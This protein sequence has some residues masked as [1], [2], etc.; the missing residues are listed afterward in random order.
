M[1]ISLIAAMGRNREIGKD[2][3]LMWRLPNDMKFFRETTEGHHV[4]MGRKNYESIPEAFRPF[5]NRVNLVLSRNLNFEAPGCVLFN[6]LGRAVRYAQD[7]AESELF[8]IGGEQ[9]YQLALDEGFV[10]TI[11]LTE[12]EGDFPG[13]EAHFPEFDKLEYTQELLL[14]QE[15]DERHAFAFKVVKYTRI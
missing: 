1:E 3:T 6:E 2:N 11:Y 14:T 10:T 8:I 4:L 12:V 13:A 5:K 9:I 7:G 15:A